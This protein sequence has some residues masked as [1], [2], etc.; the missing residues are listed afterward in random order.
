MV[1]IDDKPP[2]WPLAP[3]PPY[4]RGSSSSSS[5]QQRKRPEQGLDQEGF[6]NASPNATGDGTVNA[7]LDSHALVQPRLLSPNSL[8]IPG[9]SRDAVPPML[10]LTA[11]SST[12][13]FTH[14][15]HGADPPPFPRDRPPMT[16][17]DL[18]QH[19]LL[20]IVQLS[21]LPTRRGSKQEGTSR[22]NTWTGYN[23][24]NS[25]RRDINPDAKGEY[26]GFPRQET[27]RDGYEMGMDMTNEEEW[28]E[29]AMGL[30][31]L[32]MSVRLVNRGL[33]VA[34]MHVLRSTYLPLYSLNIKP[35]YTS[36][37]FP[38]STMDVP[39]Y[40]PTPYDPSTPVSGSYTPANSS[41]LLTT[42]RETAILDKFLLL[43]LR[44]DVLTSEST[45]HLSSNHNMHSTSFYDYPSSRGYSQSEC[46][47]ADF[48]ILFSLMQP[49][50]RLEDLVRHYGLQ[51]GSI[52]LAPSSSRLV[53]F[54][55]VS[56]KL[57]EGG[58]RVGL[59]ISD[60]KGRKRVICEY[61]RENKHEKLEIS[62]KKLAKELLAVLKQS[63]R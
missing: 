42:Q 40:T 8:Q 21:C 48:N 6:A 62:A 7:T 10:N 53:S 54:D 11:N 59:V 39:T 20:Y 58:R 44:Q 22:A 47:N 33:Y 35:P 27:Y 14:Y 19:I 9:S 29:H 4:M 55:Y 45:L 26:R 24:N 38:T 56:I 2:N 61:L 50:A 3:P 43:K 57:S 23:S 41:P 32:A 31:H 18:P 15:G 51:N 25:W 60:T 63:R 5:S 12:S 37:P 34:C 17:L 13:S 46:T 49:T 36:D 16:L 28:A 52:T 1:I 30:Y